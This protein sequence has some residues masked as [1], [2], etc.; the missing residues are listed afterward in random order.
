M[1]HE[2]GRTKEERRRET[3]REM[4]GGHPTSYEAETKIKE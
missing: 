1:V 3:E 4:D 2:D